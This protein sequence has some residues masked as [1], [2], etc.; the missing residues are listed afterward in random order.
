MLPEYLQK[1]FAPLALVTLVTLGYG[2]PAAA[3]GAGGA[4]SRLAYDGSAPEWLR[5]VG[6][7]Q[8]PG[9]RFREGRRSH[10][11]E[12]CS[13]TLVAR[14]SSPRADTIVTAW[15]C[16]EYYRDLSKSITFTLLPG[17]ADALATEATRLADG[18]GMHADWAILRLRDPV[19]A[20]R[21]TA[22]T[23]GTERAD[24]NR[25]IAMA[26]YSRDSGLGQGGARLTWDPACQITRQQRRSSESDCAAHK[27]AS[28][29]A[30]VQDSAEGR[31]RLL[32]VISQ[33]DSAG[34]S[35]YIPLTGFRGAIEQFLR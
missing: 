21:V 28:G 8:V 17:S 32:G 34:L 6:K 31:P 11:L 3:A 35:T 27:G 18:G 33:G 9:I 7:L 20:D 12:D 15:H 14:A 2:M 23:P 26:G 29:G 10:H 22:L 4:D 24:P 19:P 13:A 16:L 25:S 5:A 30:V 1:W